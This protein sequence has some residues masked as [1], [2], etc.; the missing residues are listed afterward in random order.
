VT[1]S[2]RG[3]L[4]REYRRVAEI[5]GPLVFLRNVRRAAYGALVEILLPEGGVRHGQ[6]IDASEDFCAIQVFEETMSLSVETTRIRFAEEEALVD[7]SP[8]A[9][10]R[11]LDGLGRPRDGLPPFLPAARVPVVGSPINPF[12]RDQPTDFIQ[13]G[14]STI[15]GLNTLVRGQKLPIFSGAGLPANEIAAQILRQAKVR[16]SGEE[17]AVVFA[18]MGITAR[19]AQFFMD[20]FAAS[21]GRERTTLYLNLAEDPPV[22]R[23][24]TPR[25]ALALAEYL[26]FEG[27]L[28]VLVV[29]TD[30]TQYCEALRQIALAR[31]EVPGRRGYPGYLYTDLATLYERAGRIKGRP[32]S[33]TQI[34]LLTMPDDD[35]THPVPDLTGYVTEGQIVL[36][37]ELHRRGIYPPIQPLPCLSRLMNL[38]I[39]AGK[40]REDHR[41]VA[42][43]LYSAYARAV[44]VRKLRDIVGEDALSDLDRTYLAF[45]E[46]FEERFINQGTTERSVEETLGLGWKLLR[47]LPRGELGRIGEELIGRYL[48]AS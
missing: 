17:F 41:G 45:G 23:L 29:L 24:L 20:S 22:E 47:R 31:R 6:V 30:M 8:A 40:T 9:L 5:R 3:V 18:G 11:V 15:D 48:E 36:S 25:F 16:A 10:G 21:G 13:I 39:G 34:P 2:A 38:G 42:D 44:D 12:A 1:P 33:V 32:G 7:V 43:Q 27:G 14:I 35:I 26:A 37:R 19:E 46:E 4:V 28:N